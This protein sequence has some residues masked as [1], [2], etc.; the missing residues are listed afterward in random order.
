M[1]AHLDT[2]FCTHMGTHQIHTPHTETNKWWMD[3]WMDRWTDGQMD[4][5]MARWMD[6]QI[7]RWVDG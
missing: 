7:D 4:E 3:G 5:W 2:N 6:G 1:Y